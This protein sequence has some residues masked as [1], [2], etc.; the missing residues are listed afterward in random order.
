MVLLAAVLAGL[1]AGLAVARWQKR[2]WEP[3]GLRF[4]WLVPIAFLP[5]LVAVYLP[6]ARTEIPVALA[7][8]G[9][10]LSQTLLLLF[11]WLNRRTVGVWVLALGTACNLLIM[12]VHG[13][14]MPISPETAGRLVSADALA[15]VQIG[16]RFGWKDVLLPLAQTQ[17]AFLGDRLLPPAGFPY[18]VAFS[19]GDVFIAIGVFWM[20]AAGSRRRIILHLEE[21]PC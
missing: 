18:Q 4:L 8:A 21:V 12:A 16:G 5:Q 3:P 20:M 17:L 19:L 15:T 11:C 1:L 7:G 14:F 9:L 2:S 10:I 6:Q 13:G